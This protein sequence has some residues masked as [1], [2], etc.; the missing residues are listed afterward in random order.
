MAA[1]ETKVLDGRAIAAAVQ[2][3]LKAKVEAFVADGGTAPTLVVIIVGDRK[4]SR[5]YVKMKI[6]TA[7]EIG[8]NS[9]LIEL[10]D[11]VTQAELLSHI[12]TL[13][14][15]DAV[16][17]ILLQLPVPEHI[18]VNHALDCISL[19]KDCDA[20]NPLNI[21]QLAL[22]GREPL[23]IACTP[24]GVMEILQR[25][26][27]TVAGKHAVVLGR[28]N[29]VGVPMALC[30][31]NANATVTI[32]HSQTED[33]AAVVKTADIV[34]AA[35]GRPEIVRGAM[36][37]PGAVVIDVGMNSL[38][39]ATKKAGFRFVGDVCYSECLGVAS[40]ITPVPGGVGPLTVAMLM[41]NTLEAAVRAREAAPK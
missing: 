37:K 26:G 23:T 9:R 31:L 12:H 30:L 33:L 34:V 32:A 1:I 39:D 25:S 27:V 41:Q 16:T 10:P 21:G 6:K 28:S 17:S 20:F 40:A 15:D 22:R 24:R 11:T 3:E 13:N 19:Q 4:D 7:A 8:I 35:V 38:P 36:L 29:I 14:D 18:D 5:S 2:A